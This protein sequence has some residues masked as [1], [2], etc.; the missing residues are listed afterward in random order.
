MFVQRYT[1]DKIR[2]NWLKK[3]SLS[4]KCSYSVEIGSSESFLHGEELPTLIV[5]SKG[6]ALHVYINGQLSGVY[7]HS[8]LDTE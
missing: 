2:R 6:H 3:S 7:P 4:Y 1:V 5:H 8:P